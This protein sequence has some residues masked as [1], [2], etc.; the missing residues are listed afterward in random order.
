MHNT[1]TINKKLHFSDTTIRPFRQ[2]P[3]DGLFIIAL[4]IF[5]FWSLV[6]VTFP[7]QFMS[8]NFVWKFNYLKVVAPACGIVIAGILY[9]KRLKKPDNIANPFILFSIYSFIF[10]SIRLLADGREGIMSFS[11]PV[12]FFVWTFCMFILSPAVFDS[13]E[14]LLIFIRFETFFIFFM[15]VYLSLRS[16]SMGL[17]MG[18]ASG[19][20]FRMGAMRYSL[21]Y[22][23][24]GYLGAV[25]FSLLCGAL[26]LFVLSDNRLEK[27]LSIV[28]IFFSFGSM[29]AASSRTYILG[30]IVLF[31][32]YIW[33]NRILPLILIKIITILCI[34]SAIYLIGKEMS[35]VN[36]YEQI[37]FVSSNRLQIWIKNWQNMMSNGFEWKFLFGNGIVDVGW[38]QAIVLAEG[39][40]DKTF[41]RFAIDNVYIEILIMYGVVGFGLLFWGF[42]RLLAKGKIFRPMVNIKDKEYKRN[43]RLLSVAN[44]SLL[45]ILVG[46]FFNSHL[47]SLGNTINSFVLPAAISVIFISE[48]TRL[49]KQMLALQAMGII[50]E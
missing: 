9:F 17:M 20:G 25:C 28:Y 24:P 39:R 3:I 33:K 23:N 35:T 16:F 29:V 27:M 48:K 18:A 13:K 4:C 36:V 43:F 11:Q 8:F 38:S 30:S 34:F 40:I 41:S 44:G 15:V 2:K 21:L 45:G 6:Q 10:V 1:A 19:G 42:Y 26:L 22:L 14:K 50:H 49:K 12:M 31:I 46:A 47:P 32:F 7:V 37:N 5:L